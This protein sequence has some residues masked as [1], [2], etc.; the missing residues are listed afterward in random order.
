M[1][2]EMIGFIVKGPAALDPTPAERAAAADSIATLVEFID[3]WFASRDD[4]A[5]SD[6]DWEALGLKAQ[7]LFPGLFDDDED[8]GALREFKGKS[9]AEIVDGF[10]DDW[11][12]VLGSADVA[13]RTDPDDDHQV[14]LFAGN[15]TCGDAPEGFGFQF[16]ERYAPF[17]L[18]EH[19][20]IH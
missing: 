17:G 5:T 1:G 4:P 10:L 16:F 2:M 12:T 3:P 6:D 11:E 18:L 20:G 13:A 19:F 7:D 8:L 9:A 15:M 14:L